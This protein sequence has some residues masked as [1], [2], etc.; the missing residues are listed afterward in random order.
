MGAGSRTIR[1]RYG[2]ARSCAERASRT[3]S[4]EVAL[5]L[6]TDADWHRQRQ[7]VALRVVIVSVGIRGLL[8]LG[9]LAKH[10]FPDIGRALDQ[11][12]ALFFAATILA[13]AEGLRLKAPTTRNTALTSQPF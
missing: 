3:Y 1:Q 11:F 13:F 10:P 4:H 8:L 12:N 9:P 6:P 7:T 5:Y 2:G